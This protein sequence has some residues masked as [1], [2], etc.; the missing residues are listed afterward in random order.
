MKRIRNLFIFLCL[1]SFIN[2]SKINAASISSPSTIGVGNSFTTSVTVTAATWSVKLNASGPVSGCS[3]NV[4][5]YTANLSETT[6]TFQTTCKATGVGTINLSLSGDITNGSG[7]TSNLS[8]SKTVS[9]VQSTNTNPTTPSNPTS[10][11]SAINSLKSLSIDGVTLDPKFDNSRKTYNVTLPNTTEKIKI[12]ASTTDSKASLTG[13]G[14]KNVSEGLNKFKVV[15]TAE[16]GY[17]KTYTLNVTIEEEPIIVTIDGKEYTLVRKKTALPEISNFYS[18]TTL[19]IQDKTIAAYK[20][21]ITGYILVGLKDTEGNIEL[22]IYDAD[23]NIYTLYRELKFSQITLFQLDMDEKLIP[24]NF[25]KYQITIGEKEVNVYKIN[26]DSNYALIYGLNIE[27]GEKNIYKYDSKEN[28]L[29]IY[30]REELKQLETDK[31]QYEKLIIILGGVIA[32]LILLLTVVIS[33]KSNRKKDNDETLPK[34]EKKEKKKKNKKAIE[35]QNN[36]YE[37][38]F[39][40]KEI[41]EDKKEQKKLIKEEKQINKELKKANKT[42]KKNQKKGTPEF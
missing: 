32:F 10:T 11:K 23:K 35:E 6:K 20:G 12:N 5:G 9:V 13:I 2:I 26:K 29:Q 16:N 14:E 18:D 22:Y 27:T 28:T 39:S 40:N 21:D 8:G 7:N 15:V 36:K 17:K 1:L 38:T 19:T 41:K 3:I 37:E 24:S 30:E 25:K 34:K 31:K 42:N 33:V 4:V